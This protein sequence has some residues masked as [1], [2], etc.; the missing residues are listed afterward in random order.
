VGFCVTE[1]MSVSRSIISGMLLSYI[2]EVGEPGAFVAR[3]H[4]KFSTSPA[5]G[6]AGFVVPAECARKFGREFTHRKREVFKTELEN[7]E[8]PGRWERKGASIFRPDTLEKYPQQ[9]RVFNSLVSTLRAMGGALFYYVDEKPVGTPKQT[10]L[11]VV[12]RET[13]A[14]RET[15]NR[16]STHAN[17]EDKNLL[18]MIDQITEKTRA[19]RLPNMYGHILGRAAEHPE[20]NRILEPPMHVDSELSS[21]IQFADWVA[22]C[23]TRAID[24]QLIEKSRFEWVAATRAVEQVRGAFTHESK[25]HLYHR[26]LNDFHHSDIFRRARPMYPTAV[27]HLIG[28]GLDPAVFHKVH[29]AAE[30]AHAR[31]R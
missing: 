2:D 28:D 10:S 18:V 3:D 30:R 11:D 31:G 4:P 29:A 1:P 5:F 22:A 23:V 17:A 8:N 16:L 7:V 26:S 12:E 13:V 19:E 14:M 24:Y 25:L 6:Y 15:L 9:I 27:G 21:N 20:M